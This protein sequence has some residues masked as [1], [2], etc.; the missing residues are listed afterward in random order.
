MA[1]LTLPAP[2][3]RLLPPSER[4]SGSRSV[5][6]DATSWDEA[7]REV[8]DR[9]PTLA[10]RVLTAADRVAPG[11]AVVLNDEVQTRSEERALRLRPTDELCLIAA[12]AGG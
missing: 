11:F 5:A 7:V 1:R 12:L 10:E 3:F 4:P 8:R 6:I 2:L 9:F